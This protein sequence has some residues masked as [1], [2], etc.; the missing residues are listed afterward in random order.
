MPDNTKEQI[1]Q[2]CSIILRKSKPP[3]KSNISKEEYLVLKSLKS[4]PNVVVL[5][6]DKGGVTVITNRKDYNDKMIDHLNNSGCY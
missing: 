1:R 5:K 2:D 4:N 6:A 3:P